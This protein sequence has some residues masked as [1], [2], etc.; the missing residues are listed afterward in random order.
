MPPIIV[1]SSGS[2]E[3]PNHRKGYPGTP[4][5][6]DFI[7]S[8][9]SKG[10]P[11]V[12]HVEEMQGGSDTFYLNRDVRPGEERL[13]TWTAGG[14]SPNIYGYNF[15]TD[16]IFLPKGVNLEDIIIIGAVERRGGE[17]RI[18]HDP[19][20]VYKRIFPADDSYFEMI[21]MEGNV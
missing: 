12:N 3:S 16:R 17:A 9:Q 18:R 8:P 1:N 19:Y 21:W 2:P 4:E 10:F 20:G 5:N 7:I 14:G 6:D 11:S 13:P 15:E